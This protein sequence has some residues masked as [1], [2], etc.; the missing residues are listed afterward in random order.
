M[1]SPTGRVSVDKK[2]DVLL[3]SDVLEDPLNWVRVVSLD[4]GTVHFYHVETRDVQPPPP[5]DVFSGDVCVPDGWF[6]ITSRT[7]R[8]FLA[9]TRIWSMIEQRLELANDP[10][11][12]A[13][14][15]RL[16]N[17]VRVRDTE[18]ALWRYITERKIATEMSESDDED[19]LKAI[20]L[21]SDDEDDF[22]VPDEG[23]FLMPQVGGSSMVSD[24]T[25]AGSSSGR[26]RPQ[27][28]PPKSPSRGGKSLIG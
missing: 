11:E 19:N 20:D 16:K 28:P 1:G 14:K 21:E 9:N 24:V 17:L 26:R 4:A 10:S 3:Y 12:K 13:N 2:R 6:R 27:T 8:I 23:G 22:E 7:G 25:K 18:R 15:K 5:A